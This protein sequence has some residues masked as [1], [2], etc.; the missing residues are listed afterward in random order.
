M[1]AKLRSFVNPLVDIEIHERKKLIYFSL[2]LI[3]IVAAYSLLKSIKN[4]IF[5]GLVG[6]DYQP[7][8][9]ILTILIMPLLMYVYSK[10]VDNWRRYQL[11]IL[12]SIIYAIICL[13][14]AGFLLDPIYGL[15][16]TL[17][18]KDRI[19][20]WLFYLALDF[21]PIFVVTTFWA[22]LNSISSPDSAK[23]SY[24]IIVAASKF[25]GIISPFIGIWLLDWSA[26]ETTHAICS[27][28]AISG[29]LLLGAAWAIWQ[30][31]RRVPGRYLHGYEAA[32]E[33]EKQKRREHTDKTGTWQGFRLMLAEPYVLG[34]FGMLYSYEL[35]SSIIDY[36]KDY[37]VSM[38]YSNQVGPMASFGLWYTVAWQ[39]VGLLFAL[40]G[41]SSLLNRIGIQNCLLM[42]PLITGGLIFTLFFFP[43]LWTIVFVM[44]VLR[45]M[46][47]GFN[48]PLREMLYIPTV[49]DIK[50][51][52]KAWT[53]S[54]GK[55]FSKASGAGIN[56][57]LLG[58]SLQSFIA[59]GTFFSVIIIAGWTAASYFVARRYNKTIEDGS[60]IGEES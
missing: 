52:S 48:V 32:Y 54:F 14:F 36:Q 34:I 42:V 4:S 49:K 23:H 39:A 27:V 45:A 37:M 28:L 3:F 30:L 17:Q 19:L 59:K 50:F 26:F 55:T 24:G 40:F 60:V 12:F 51:K 38:M 2:C 47:Y 58:G 57:A 41:T 10:T 46:N 21:Y 35:L 9:K 13:A 22:F 15:P 8:A 20:G 1:L 6:R 7:E 11:V 31:K 56:K 25:S 44:V 18:S 53:D 33:I 43:T 5:F 16:N 29:I